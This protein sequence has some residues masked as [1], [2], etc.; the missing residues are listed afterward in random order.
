[1]DVF[2]VIS[3]YL[4]IGQILT[5]TRASRFSFLDFYARRSLR[6]LPPFFVVLV[7]T[8]LGAV[9][10]LVT[11]RELKEFGWSELF[12]SLMLGNHFFLRT[13]D[14]F[15]IEAHL[16]PLL[17]FWTLSVEEQFY[18][19]APLLIWGGTHLYARR[20]GGPAK[21]VLLAMA[22][23][24]FVLSLLGC[25]VFT[26]GRNPAFFLMPLRGWE[27]IAGGMLA[28]AAAGMRRLGRA[29]NEC[30][31]ALGAMLVIGSIVLLGDV[32]YPS[33]YVLLPVAG[34]VAI[35]LTGA[36]EPRNVVAR[37][38]AQPP[39]IVIG[40]LSYSWYLW[41]WPLIVFA[42]AAPLGGPR[43]SLGLAAAFLALLF[44]AASYVLIE[45][46]IRLRRRDIFARYGAKRIVQGAVLGCA[47]FAVL[48]GVVAECA[49]F[50][51]HGYAGVDTTPLSAVPDGG[52]APE[53]TVPEE[54][55]CLKSLPAGPKG[56]LL[57]DSF[58]YAMYEAVLER[59]RAAGAYTI[60][61][62]K[63]GCVPVIG[64]AVGRR[65]P[66]PAE[67]L[68]RFGGA[69]QEKPG[70]AIMEANWPRNVT[71]DFRGR[72]EETL[73][74]VR[75]LG[76]ARILV[77]A[78]IP[79]FPKPALDCALRADRWGLGRNACTTPR[80]KV[81]AGRA[82]IMPLLN[83]M[84]GQTDD[85]RV[86]DP[87]GVY[88]DKETCRPFEGNAIFYRDNDHLSGLGAQRIVSAFDAD[89]RWVFGASQ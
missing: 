63:P 65:C 29:T 80:E 51:A 43:L 13:G 66:P 84:A 88:C 85:V 17:H 78:P 86:I 20:S 89:F 64:Y 11:P 30:L 53:T 15:A 83:A 62:A 57:G 54:S 10:F 1:M 40:L 49:R 60:R 77:V 44:A 42:H 28:D 37:V 19:V 58:A 25:I 56:L 38:L 22:S 6:I 7:A 14:Y 32:P 2:F 76:V 23:G 47:L 52:C 68:A 69:A 8:S 67:S 26:E 82:K 79:A 18:L 39:M 46:R 35:I 70:Y 9:V 24:I 59:G 48:G 27:F 73:A 71:D 4:I 75:S 87:L 72:F 45:R 21:A 3:G 33:G 34:A 55:A 5:A 16:K 50:A 36:A 41:H 12:S 31:A 74:V 81:E 61:Y